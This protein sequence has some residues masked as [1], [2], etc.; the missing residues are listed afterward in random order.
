MI[1]TVP[2]AVDGCRR[3]LPP[4]R[5]ATP[6][7]WTV[8]TSDA[9]GDTPL[10]CAPYCTGRTH[11]HQTRRPPRGK[12]RAA[13]GGS[14]NPMQP[15]HRCPL[16]GMPEG[17]KLG[18]PRSAEEQVECSGDIASRG[19]EHA[20]PVLRYDEVAVGAG[21]RVVE[22]KARGERVAFAVRSGTR[23]LGHLKANRPTTQG[24]RQPA[25]RPSRPAPSDLRPQVTRRGRLPLPIKVHGHAN[26]TGG[27]PPHVA[28]STS[29]I[30]TR[31]AFPSGLGAVRQLAPRVMTFCRSASSSAT[32]HAEIPDHKTIGGPNRDS[33][34]PVPVARSSG[35]SPSPARC[36]VPHGRMSDGSPASSTINC[37]A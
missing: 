23:I 27:C 12:L 7:S 17:F 28:T 37:P 16:T 3:S 1:S 9:L 11:D 26:D 15:A 6:G 10:R 22:A 2:P 36:Q 13:R 19:E 24:G 18:V 21:Q 34:R 33:R 35:Q 30:S 14:P 29:A 32:R 20:K 8:L 4:T 5:A 25:G 31:D